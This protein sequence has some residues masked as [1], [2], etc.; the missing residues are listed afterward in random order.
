MNRWVHVNSGRS[1]HSLLQ[2]QCSRQADTATS[3]YKEKQGRVTTALQLVSGPGRIR[4]LVCWKPTPVL[5][6]THQHVLVLQTRPDLP[7]RPSHM[8]MLNRVRGSPRWGGGFTRVWRPL[9]PGP[10]PKW[11]PGG[12]E[13]TTSPS[14]RSSLVFPEISN[15]GPMVIG[16]I[17]NERL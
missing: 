5:S 10:H 11:A 15:V 12:G 3:P 4:T 9:G 13:E 7:P 8:L 14:G 16:R 6:A 2:C 1:T 17:G